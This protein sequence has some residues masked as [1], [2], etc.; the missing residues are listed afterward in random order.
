MSYPAQYKITNNT[1][2]FDLFKKSMS[3]KVGTKVYYMDKGIDVEIKEI[4]EFETDGI[5]HTAW[6][7]IK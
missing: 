6:V 7:N 5:N 1:M 3:K 4:V 2:P